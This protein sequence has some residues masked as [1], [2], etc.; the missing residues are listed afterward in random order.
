MKQIPAGRF[1][2]G[3][4]LCFSQEN[5]ERCKHKFLYSDN[6]EALAPSHPVSVS[7]FRLENSPVDRSVIAAVTRIS[8]GGSRD[9]MTYQDILN[10]SAFVNKL[11]KRHFRLPSEAEWEYTMVAGNPAHPPWDMCTEPCG[12]PFDGPSSP[13]FPP[14]PFGISGGRS[15]E[16]VSDCW[17]PNFRG[18]PSDGSAWDE[19]NCGR[20]IRTLRQGGHNSLHNRYPSNLSEIASAVPKWAMFRLAETVGVP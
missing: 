14:N 12:L 20:G 19:D 15:Y 6:G 3:T 7:S 2:M 9:E 18:A 17:H 11:T 5:L 10:F 1:K 8:G 16:F 13:T 4:D